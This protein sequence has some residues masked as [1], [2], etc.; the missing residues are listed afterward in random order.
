MKIIIYIEPLRTFTSGTPHRG[1]LLKLIELRSDDE[2]VLVLRKGDLPEH[3]QELFNKLK[4][5]SNWSLRY[6]KRSRKIVNMLAL[7]HFRNHCEIKVKGDIYLSFDAEYLGSKN[8]PQ[9][10]TV[11]DLSSVRNSKSSSI[12]PIKRIARK[13]TIENGVKHANHIVAISEFTK[14]DLLDYFD[15]AQEKITVIHNGIDEKWFQEES[16]SHKT[17]HNDDYWIWW[18]AYSQRKNLERLLQA[19]EL[20]LKE[21]DSIPDLYLVGNKNEY[22]ERLLLIIEG[23]KVLK[24]KVKIYPQQDIDKLKIL[25]S[26]SVGLVFPSLYEGFGLPVIEAYSQG[27]TVLTSNVSSLPEISGDLGVLVDP[28]DII[29]IKNG[30]LKLNMM[31]QYQDEKLKQWAEQFTYEKAAIKYSEL[32]DRCLKT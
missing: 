6:E 24:R 25:V 26:N 3:M 12:S 9:I 18:G 15:I 11:H 16:I 32:I 17:S 30:L 7:L 29:D 4:K 1:V 28:N 20:L 19:Y 13:F 2:F 31:Q 5:F 27:V 10:V 21:M 23:S 8:N 14:K 22:F